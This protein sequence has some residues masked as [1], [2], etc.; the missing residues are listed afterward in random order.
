[1]AIAL[2]P[3]VAS[4][5]SWFWPTVVR[6][7]GE[8]T[9]R[10]GFP[11]VGG[12]RTDGALCSLATVGPEATT[13]AGPLER[14]DD[15]AAVDDYTSWWT[16][17]RPAAPFNG[18]DSARVGRLVRIVLSEAG[19]PRA[20]I[21][22]YLYGV[23]D[24]RG[25]LVAFSGLGMSAAGW[26]NQRFAEVAARKGF[27]TFAPIRDETPEASTGRLAFDP[28]RE[29]RR[30]RAAAR[31]IAASAGLGGGPIAFIG[32]S[33]GGMEA[34]L[35]ARE[36]WAQNAPR[37]AAVLDPLLD[38]SAATAHLDSFWHSFAT[39]SMQAYFRRILRVRYGEPPSTSFR[40]LL[41]RRRAD[42]ETDLDRDAPSVWLC[43]D[44][45]RTGLAVFVSEDDPVLGTRQSEFARRCG[46]VTPA[47]VSGHVGLACRLSLFDEIVDAAISCTAG[48]G[49]ASE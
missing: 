47:R 10:S 11:L 28:V 20:A 39:D 22:G 9:F 27:A 12:A 26:V 23:A 33:L 30:A 25:L 17:T 43:R 34:L 18:H 14:L 15:E 29:A 37:C 46:M 1:M 7:H 8:E 40:D 45:Q 36:P 42:S 4:G 21:R 41:A 38:P 19:E 3:L 49:G 16:S 13:V 35:A 2:L 44:T 31:K 24:P 48:C 5:C 32:V 6:T